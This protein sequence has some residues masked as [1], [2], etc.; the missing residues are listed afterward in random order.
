MSRT[1]RL[2]LAAA[3]ASALLLIA[4][5]WQLRPARFHGTTYEPLAPAPDFSLV[6][7]RGQPVTRSSLAGNPTLL[8]F[9]Y[10]RCPDVC[11]RTL[12]RLRLATRDLPEVRVVLITV[13]PHR[14]TPA[15]LARYVTRF[16][17]GVI[18]LTGDSA[19]VAQAMAG[20]GAH[21][22]P[23]V[24]HGAHAGGPAASLGHSAVVYGIDR[25]GN[26][27]VVISEGASEDELRDD[28]R[29]LARL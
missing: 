5:G 29:T 15:E 14:D 6:D 20:Y 4:I 17:P 9:G 3:A 10:T 18:G 1:L 28:V 2:G 25:A 16:G 21:T 19:S 23:V 26:L 8:F 27:Q 13:D 24:P 7:H 22:M 12:S 11:P